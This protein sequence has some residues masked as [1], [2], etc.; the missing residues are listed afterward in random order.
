MKDKLRKFKLAQQREA[1]INRNVHIVPEIW[2]LNHYCV[3]KFKFALAQAFNDGFTAGE[4][5]NEDIYYQIHDKIIKKKLHV[6]QII[7]YMLYI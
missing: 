6:C 5:K 4:M 3:D 7:K 1:S 2:T